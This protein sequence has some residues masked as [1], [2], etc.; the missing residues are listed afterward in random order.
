VTLGEP[1]GE[2]WHEPGDTGKEKV[3]VTIFS[4]FFSPKRPGERSMEA[5]CWLKNKNFERKAEQF[6][7][8]D[9]GR[10]VGSS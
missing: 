5:G 10:D 4:Y 8:T 7:P 9:G 1:C 2:T 3:A 6:A